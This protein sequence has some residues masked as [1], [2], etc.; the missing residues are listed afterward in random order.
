VEIS[1]EEI[2]KAF[3]KEA[4]REAAF[5]WL[6]KKYQQRLYWQVRR[7]VT[8][9]A[10]ADDVMQNVLIK[11]WRHLEKF[12]N[13][14]SL[15]TWLYRISTNECLTFIENKK[16]KTSVSLDT[17]EE[18]DGPQIQL[19]ADPYFNGD[20]LETKLQKAILLLPEKQRI[21]FN[22]RYYEEMPYEKMSEILGTSV[23]ALKASYHHAAKKIES[24]LTN[25]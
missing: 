12:R 17:D 14:S 16:K 8:E 20:D 15:H 2:L 18:E 1:D 10:D 21:V 5:G 22:L 7:M 11:V 3:S 4:T 19:A 13:D 6:L 9:H 25:L 24:F 23:G